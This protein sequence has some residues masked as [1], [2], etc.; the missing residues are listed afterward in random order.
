[1]NL[2]KTILAVFVGVLTFIVVQGIMTL[3]L[4][5]GGSSDYVILGVSLGVCLVVTL[6]IVR[7]KAH[8]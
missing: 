3:L 2:G 8:S 6:S 1:M 4:P 5:S 7:R